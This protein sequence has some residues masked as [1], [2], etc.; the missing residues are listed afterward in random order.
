MILILFI[1]IRILWKS[2]WLVEGLVSSLNMSCCT[3]RSQIHF[4]SV[5][6]PY[7]F[8]LYNQPHFVRLWFSKST[9]QNSF[10]IF[11]STIKNIKKKSNIIKINKKSIFLNYLIFI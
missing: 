7:I 10:L 11:Y 5:V 2:E 9:K 6:F 1:L 4:V 8:D 3:L